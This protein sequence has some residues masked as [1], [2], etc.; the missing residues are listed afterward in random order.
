MQLFSQFLYTNIKLCHIIEETQTHT[1][2]CSSFCLPCLT[3]CLFFSDGDIVQATGND[4]FQSTVMLL[5]H[6]FSQIFH[7][8]GL[9][10]LL[11]IISYNN[12]TQ[13]MQLW[14]GELGV[15]RGD[16]CTDQS[17]PL[18]LKCEGLLNDP[19]GGKKCGG[20]GLEKERQ[21]FNSKFKERKQNQEEI[22][23]WNDGVHEGQEEVQRQKEMAK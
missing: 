5:L 7:F 11:C 21:K 19:E 8:I 10:Y 2:R 14:A 9:N 23:F 17:D 12:T 4:G 16:S 1:S 13:N 20:G 3:G 22:I 18:T 15:C 6:Y